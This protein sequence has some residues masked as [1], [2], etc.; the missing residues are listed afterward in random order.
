MNYK[1]LLDGLINMLLIGIIVEGAVSAVFSISA[2]RSIEQK[3]VVQSTREALTFLV[4]LLFVYTVES[5]RL[6]KAAGIRF[7]M[8]GDIVIS[9]MVLTRIAGFIRDLMNR[10]RSGS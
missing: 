1:L 9:S 3:R 10:I 2:M 6:F 8:M 7:P 4:C 5:L